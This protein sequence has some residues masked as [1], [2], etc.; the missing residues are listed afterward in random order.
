MAEESIEVI[1]LGASQ[2]AGFPQPG[3]TCQNCSAAHVNPDMAEMPSSIAIIDHTAES[4]WII[5]ATPA[6]PAQFSLLQQ[7]PGNYSFKGI[8]LTHAHIGHY[9]GLMYFGREAMNDK[10]L[11]VHASARL[12]SFLEK[13][14]PWSFLVSLGNISLVP[15]IAD[16][17]IEITPI[18]SV[19]PVEV[20]HRAEFTDTYAFTIQ[21][22]SRRLFYC[23]DIDSWELWSRDIVS[24]LSDI[25]YALLDGTFY[26]AGEIDRQCTDEIPH[27]PVE[28]TVDKLQGVSSK[29]TFVHMNHSNPLYRDGSERNRLVDMG[30]RIGKKGQKWQL[31]GKKDSSG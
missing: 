8:F 29:I 16:Q 24:F 27:P 25:D 4:F 22:P 15:I 2:D 13:N 12:C 7:L 6:L 10:G 31:Y 14:K 9:T 11:P 19:L 5:D 28:Q 26:N 30:F 3:C 20:P 21:G 1:L 18:L 23:P 17:P